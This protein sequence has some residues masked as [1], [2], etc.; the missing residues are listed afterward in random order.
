MK[1]QYDDWTLQQLLNR[2][3]MINEDKYAAATADDRQK[4]DEETEAV[5]RY[6]LNNFDR[7]SL[8]EWN[9]HTAGIGHPY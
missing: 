7:R 2:L 9:P 3:W 5:Q 8:S 6:I 1:S 4:L